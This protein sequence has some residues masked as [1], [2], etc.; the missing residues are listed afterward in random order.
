MNK[1]DLAAAV[2]EMTNM[3]RAEAAKAVDA[4][5]DIITQNMKA[6]NEVRILGFGNFVVTQ[7]AASMG[8]NPQTG[9]PMPIKAAKVA[10]FK[11]GKS[12]K[13]VM[14]GDLGAVHGGH[15]SVL[16]RPHGSV[17]AKRRGPHGPGGGKPTAKPHGG[18][19]RKGG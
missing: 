3:S 9:E 1:G 8:R 15:R 17:S 13:D 16:R 5:F 4:V 6:G 11:A 12:L 14:Q 7:R 18:G 10:K 2:A 19:G